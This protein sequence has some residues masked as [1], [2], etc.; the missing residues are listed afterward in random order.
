[1]DYLDGKRTEIEY[2]LIYENEKYDIYYMNTNL[3]HV[4]FINS[5]EKI[6]TL[7]IDTIL[8]EDIYES[9]LYKAVFSN[10]TLNNETF[11]YME[12]S[13]IMSYE[14]SNDGNFIIRINQNELIMIEFTTDNS[15][16][17]DKAFDFNQFL[18]Y[19]GFICFMIFMIVN[20]MYKN[21]KLPVLHV[22]HESTYKFETIGRYTGISDFDNDLKM[23][24][25]YIKNSVFEPIK[26]V[27][28]S[29]TFA[30]LSQFDLRDSKSNLLSS[31]LEFHHIFPH[32]IY[33]KMKVPKE[34]EIFS[35]K[36]IVSTK[37]RL[38][39]LLMSILTFMHF[40]IYIVKI[41]KSMDFEKGSKL[42]EINYLQLEHSLETIDFLFDF[43]YKIEDLDEKTGLSIDNWVKKEEKDIPY[44][45]VMELRNL[46]IQELKNI[47][48]KFKKIRINRFLTLK[49]AINNRKSRITD[50]TKY[51]Y[52]MLRKSNR[53]RQMS[54]EF[55]ILN[56]EFRKMRDEFS[57]NLSNGIK[58]SYEKTESL[59]DNIPEI[60]DSVVYYKTLGYEST[61][62]IQT[63]I[64]DFANNSKKID[65]SKDESI[66]KKD[67]QIEELISLVKTQTEKIDKDVTNLD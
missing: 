17:E 21:Q 39:Q 41:Y 31:V 60:I 51:E 24:K 43:T 27:Y 40:N 9:Q 42:E 47:P 49:E 65:K 2:E 26:I 8:I 37:N 14:S 36:P 11:F 30:E 7:Q 63:G 29:L 5:S 10:E 20:F 61:E 59:L 3:S 33:K 57:Y 56:E 54:S 12:I 22:Q 15:Y 13:I 1:M 50:L 25:F 58:K 44:K 28:S 46:N 55:M 6:N 38:K 19:I 52:L 23:N 45:R 48:L 67:K 62:A 64:K 18:G 66:N 4:I 34:V 16:T 32:I 35:Q 53:I